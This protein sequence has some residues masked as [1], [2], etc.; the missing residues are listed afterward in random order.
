MEQKETR[1]PFS[2]SGVAEDSSFLG[3]DAVWLTSLISSKGQVVRGGE[4]TT[5]CRNVG[6][7]TCQKRRK[8]ARLISVCSSKY[9]WR[10]CVRPKDSVQR[11]GCCICFRPQM[12]GWGLWLCTFMPSLLVYLMKKTGHFTRSSNF[13]IAN[14]RTS[15]Q[16]LCGFYLP[17]CCVEKPAIVVS[18]CGKVYIISISLLFLQGRDSDYLRD[19]QSGGPNPGRARFQHAPRPALRTNQPLVQLVPGLFPGYKAAGAWRWTPTHIWHRG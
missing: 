18:T 13:N 15:Q 14:D 11:F 7:N 9:S 4:G 12:K 1:F 17:K 6:K 10:G 19:G 8:R 3:Y 16:Q 5:F 2:H